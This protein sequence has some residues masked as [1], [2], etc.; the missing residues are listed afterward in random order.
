M[1]TILPKGDLI[2]DMHLHKYVAANKIGQVLSF[3]NKCKSEKMIKTA[4]CDNS[5]IITLFSNMLAYLN[6]SLDKDNMRE[7][8]DNMAIDSTKLDKKAS[9]TK[10]ER[11]ESNVFKRIL[12][13]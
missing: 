6:M 2:D 1:Y 4:S 5:Q 7:I 12:R 9:M 8:T 10:K 3:V 13:R 11:R